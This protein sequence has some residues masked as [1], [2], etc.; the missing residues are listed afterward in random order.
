[1]PPDFFF[2]FIISRNS[3]LKEVEYRI[4]TRQKQRL[5]A[6]FN[7]KYDIYFAA[8]FYG[9]IFFHLVWALAGLMPGSNPLTSFMLGLPGGRVIA[10]LPDAVFVIPVIIGLYMRFTNRAAL[11]IYDHQ[12]NRLFAVTPE[13]SYGL[14]RDGNGKE[15]ARLNAK[16]SRAA[17]YWEFV[18]TDNVVVFTVRDDAPDISQACR[19]FGVQGGQLRRRYGIFV[20]E[21]RAGFVFLDPSSPDRFQIH[22]EYNYA[23][24]AHPAHI[25]AAMLYIISREREHF[26]PTVF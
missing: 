5:G 26:Y 1:V 23:R 9:F 8:G 14:I 2:P 21:R 18:D 25:L 10:S 12:S 16:G 7:F 3:S 4:L 15:V 22:L 19:L 6:Y 13:L 17:R 24:L 11:E 20:Q